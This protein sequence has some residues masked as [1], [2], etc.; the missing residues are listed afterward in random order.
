MDAAKAVT[1][2]FTLDTNPPRLANISTRMQVLTGNEVMIGGFVI[3]GASN[4]TVAIVATGPSL[5]QFGIVNA[6]ANPKITLVRSSDQVTLATNDD[7]QAAPNAA[8]LSA[9][10]FAPPNPLEP[11]ILVNLAPG[12][13]TAI[14][15]GVGGGTGVSL[16]GVYEVDGPTIPLINISTRGK[17][18]TG[19]DVMIGGFVIQGSG[20]QAV[21]IVATGPSL[22]PF[23]IA[24]PLANP[25]ITLVRSS[26]QAV[27]DTND[28]WQS[29]PN[30]AQLQAAGFAPSNALEAGIYTTLP[31]GAYTAIV[32]GVGGGTGV[33]VI[34][35]YKAN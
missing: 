28:D 17:V 20:P 19:N 2:T 7:W 34:G 4:K 21:A 3:G 10:G 9:A 8:Q 27:L 35:V 14:V 6:L 33:A 30:A 31:P 22:A 29:H 18:L 15:E 32:E 23:G 24:N 26:D 25:K 5:A 1:A 12:A 11:A 16:I 13:Y